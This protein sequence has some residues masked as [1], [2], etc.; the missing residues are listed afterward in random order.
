MFSQ[1]SQYLDLSRIEEVTGPQNVL[2]LMA[3]FKD[4]SNEIYAVNTLG[5][6]VFYSA[7]MKD[8]KNGT[9][10]ILKNGEALTIE[11]KDGTKFIRDISNDEFENRYATEF[12]GGEGFCQR[13]KG[14]SFGACYRAE[15]DEFCDS[16]ISC[17]ALATQAPI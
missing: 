14:E 16:F 7:A 4:N 10:G 5:S 13:E 8:D 3:K 11:F 6:E 15:S 17:V 9:I 12:H 1:L 2:I